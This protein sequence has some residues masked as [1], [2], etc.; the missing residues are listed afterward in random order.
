M[1]RKISKKQQRANLEFRLKEVQGFLERGTVPPPFP[2]KT[3]LQL[4]SSN[5]N[6]VPMT[7]EQRATYETKLA[8]I[9]EKL[10]AMG[11]K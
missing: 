6:E 11:T 5:L 10:A 2:F 1:P 9:Q 3:G 8:A 7:P 4:G